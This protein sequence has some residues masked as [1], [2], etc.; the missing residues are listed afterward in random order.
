MQKSLRRLQYGVVTLYDVLAFA[1]DVFCMLSDV[2]GRI[3]GQPWMALGHALDNAGY[4]QEI[5]SRL[6]TAREMCGEHGWTETVQRIAEVEH[7]ISGKVVLPAIVQSKCA[8]LENHLLRVLKGQLFFHAESKRLE[9]YWRWSEERK[10]WQDS[11]PYASMEMGNAR[12][13]YLFGQPTACVFHAMRALE[14]GL[15]TLAGELEV[16]VQTRDQW[17]TIINNIESTIKTINGP[18]AGKDWKQ[19]QESYA[20]AALHFRYLKNAWRN[21]VMHGRRHSYEDKKAS[22]IMQHVTDFISELKNELRLKEPIADK[23][24]AAIERENTQ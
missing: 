20:E 4:K 21:H 14:I 2:I 6:A 22:Q 18:H 1:A 10:T 12:L 23:L 11:F 13:C 7:Y 5:L 24:K 3:V 19:K 16:S 9:E 15:L 8:D 17:E